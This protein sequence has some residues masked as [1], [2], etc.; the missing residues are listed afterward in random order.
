MHA[1]RGALFLP[2]NPAQR[3]QLV[4]LLC[5]LFVFALGDKPVIPE[6]SHAFVDSADSGIEARKLH[7][8]FWIVGSNLMYLVSIVFHR[9][10]EARTN[11]RFSPVHVSSLPSRYMPG[12]VPALIM[13]ML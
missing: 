7:F 3:V 5:E 9:L 11:R 6:G 4:D 12:I 8:V 13:F 2:F 1:F 10:E